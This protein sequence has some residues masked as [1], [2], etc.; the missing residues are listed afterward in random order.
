MPRSYRLE[1]AGNKEDI[2]YKHW[3][4]FLNAQ[5]VE[6]TFNGINPRSVVILMVQGNL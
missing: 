2:V 3:F 5:D 1:M 6:Q 4:C